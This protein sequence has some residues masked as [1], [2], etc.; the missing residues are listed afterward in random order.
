M[1]GKYEND[2]YRCKRCHRVLKQENAKARGYGNSCWKKLIK[3]NN[4]LYKE[5]EP[6]I[7][8]PPNSK[9]LREK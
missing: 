7:I 5:F 1:S 3:M 4:Q 8:L 6:L 9:E 2:V